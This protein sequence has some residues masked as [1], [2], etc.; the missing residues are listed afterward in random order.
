[1]MEI[2]DS[3]PWALFS[4]LAMKTWVLEWT[5]KRNMVASTIKYTSARCPKSIQ[6][7]CMGS[8]VWLTIKIFRTSNS[9]LRTTTFSIHKFRWMSSFWLPKQRREENNR[10]SSS[11]IRCKTRWVMKKLRASTWCPWARVRC[12]QTSRTSD[13]H[14]SREL[15]QRR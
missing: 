12:Q 5:I 3:S 13:R 4:S 9:T 11:L 2:L 1:M 6:W 15:W 7:A 14:K 8:I 10:R